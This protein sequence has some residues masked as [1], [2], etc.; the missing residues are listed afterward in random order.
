MRMLTILRR[1]GLRFL[2]VAGF[3]VIG[4][5]LGGCKAKTEAPQSQP[6]TEKSPVPAQPTAKQA[7]TPTP[8]APSTAKHQTV[9]KEPPDERLTQDI[10]Q[11]AKKRPDLGPPLVADPASLQ[12]LS[13]TQPVWLDKKDRCIVLQGEVCAAGYPLEFFATYSNRDYESVLSVNVTPSIVHAGL[14]AVGATP[15]HPARFQPTF[16]PPT[17]TEIAV[18][19][20]WKDAKG[21]MQRVPAQQWIRNIKTK[22][23]LDSN[24]VF[25]GSMS[26]TDEATEGVLSGRFGRIDL[27]VE[28]TQR[29]ARSA[30][31]QLRGL[32]R[33]Q[34]R[35]VQGA[36]AAA[37]DSGNTFAQAD[38]AREACRYQPPG[39][40]NARHHARQ[41]A[42]A[43]L[44]AVAAATAWLA[45]VDREQYSQAWE[46][47]S[48][49][50]RSLVGR[51][52][53]VQKIGGVTKTARR[54]QVTR[55]RFQDVRDESAWNARRTVCH[56]DVQD[57][58]C[59]REIQD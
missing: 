22:K 43:E 38:F 8:E 46:T 13:P 19:V 49:F 28:P 29:D 55:T 23:V 10:E 25:A 59:Q 5:A 36:S 1:P 3:T 20:C 51:R 26:V 30:D 15:G 2:A 44:K 56:A 52:D 12:R 7:P 14:L 54:R 24:W 33:S 47:A 42:D 32:G 50:L 34:L 48:D 21:L 37:R 41:R 17:G 16:S 58:V 35:G 11:I 6:A 53:F 18:E 31:P 39:G 27:R 9:A 4:V 57:I 45:L 40:K